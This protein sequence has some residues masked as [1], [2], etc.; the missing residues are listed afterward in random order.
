MTE[1]VGV[2]GGTW[3]VC[4]PACAPAITTVSATT[5]PAKPGTITNLPRAS[6]ALKIRIFGLFVTVVSWFDWVF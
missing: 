3:G 1:G 4:A 6:R 5:N 2:S